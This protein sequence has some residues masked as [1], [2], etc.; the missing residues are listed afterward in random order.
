MDEMIV[1]ALGVTASALSILSLLPQVIRTWRTQSAGD[2]SAG[3]LITALVSMV[4]WAVYGVLVSASAVIWANV[5]TFLQ[6]SVI[7]A[8]KLRGVPRTAASAETLAIPP[9]G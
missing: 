6:A 8:I 4:L 2:I 1:T 9:Q 5:L 7:L 3:W